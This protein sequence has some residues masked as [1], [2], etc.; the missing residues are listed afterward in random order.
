MGLKLY[1]ALAGKA[2]L[3]ATEF[4]KSEETL[5]L[6]PNSKLDGP[7]GQL[8]GVKYWDEQFDDARLALA[9]ARTAASKSALLINYCVATGLIYEDGK[10]TGLHVK[11]V[12]TGMAYDIKAKSVINAKQVWADQFRMADGQAT[13]RDV[14]AMVAPIQGVHIAVDRSF[15][16]GN[17]AMLIHETVDRRVL[18]AVPWLGKTILGA[19]N[20]PRGNLVREPLAYSEEVNL[21]LN[22]SA[23]YLTKAPTHLDIKSIWVGLRPLV[24]PAADDGDNTK[25]LAREHTILVSKSGLKT[26]KGGKWATCRAMAEYV[27][28]RRSHLL[29]LDAALG[30]SLTASVTGPWQQE[31]EVNPALKASSALCDKYLLLP[32]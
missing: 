21:I 19:T 27:L 28:E 11:D 3:G 31:T 12:K 1:D 8:K 15:L 2:G 32:D 23:Q 24:K 29:F 30:K 10:V 17:Q 6:L 13:G 14:K 18:F 20:T 26:L 5:A 4:L 22:K 16:P 25:G 7:G 9:L